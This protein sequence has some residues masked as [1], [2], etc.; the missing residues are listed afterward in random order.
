MTSELALDLVR[1]AL[2]TA[3]MISAPILAVALIVGIVTSV[4][5]ASTQIHEPTLTFGPKAVAVGG[6]MLAGGTWILSQAVEFLTGIF[7]A[8]PQVSP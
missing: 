1:Q 2:F 8:M 4:V 6:T 3:G 7:A 5:Q